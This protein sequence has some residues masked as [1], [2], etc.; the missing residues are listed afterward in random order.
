MNSLRILR[1]ASN[2]SLR[3][4]GELVGVSASS[5]SRWENGLT[6]P[7]DEALAEK[8]LRLASARVPNA[9]LIRALEAR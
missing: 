6:E 2:M 1:A 7:S 5:L 4:L 3:E 9:R 8:A